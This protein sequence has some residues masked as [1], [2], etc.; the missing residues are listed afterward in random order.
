MSGPYCSSESPTHFHLEIYTGYM[1]T[2][3]VLV[4]LLT[5]QTKA[6]TLLIKSLPNF[7]IFIIKRVSE[8]LNLASASLYYRLWSTQICIC[9]YLCF[10]NKNL[11]PRQAWTSWYGKLF[12]RENQNSQY[13]VSEAAS[14]TA[15]QI[16]IKNARA[17]SYTVWDTLPPHYRSFPAMSSL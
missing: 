10:K 14:Q 2:Y 16:L 17:I 1:Y 6:P 4:R 5:N 8:L 15:E 12:Q 3:M 7:A 13:L 9:F 11:C